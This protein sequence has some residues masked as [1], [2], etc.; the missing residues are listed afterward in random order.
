[1]A[2]S[3]VFVK[4]GAVALAAFTSSATAAAV[5]TPTEYTVADV[6]QGQTFFDQF[7]FNAVCIVGAVYP[8]ML[9]IDRMLTRPMDSSTTRHRLLPRA[10]G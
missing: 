9:K 10:K 7:D 2:P 3:S 1:M 8:A 6:Y 4:A 5:V